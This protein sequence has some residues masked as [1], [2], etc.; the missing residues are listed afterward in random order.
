MAIDTTRPGRVR[1]APE[2]FL[3]DQ[4]IEVIN[5][6]GRRDFIR[7]AFLTASAAMAVPAMARAQSAGIPPFLNC[8][9]GQP[10]SACRLRPIRTACPRSTSVAWSGAKAPA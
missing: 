6:G 4:D 3:S 10:R 8:R 2:N 9:P 7:K 5:K 1:P